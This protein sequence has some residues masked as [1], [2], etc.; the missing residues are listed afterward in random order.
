MIDKFQP[1]RCVL[2]QIKL[3]KPVPIHTIAFN[4]NDAEANEF[5]HKLA[6]D[7]G[8]RYH[9]YTTHGG[10]GTGPLPYEV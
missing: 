1:P 6:L 10:V 7:S 8:G 9:C 5:L 2:S 4:C 3:R